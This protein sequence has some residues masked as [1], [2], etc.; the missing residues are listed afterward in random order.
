MR[1][2]S[3][4]ARMLAFG[5]LFMCYSA[6][7]VLTSGD[8]SNA[9]LDFDAN[10]EITEGAK[11][12]TVLPPLGDDA[13]GSPPPAFT[14]GSTTT[15]PA[16]DKPSPGPVDDNRP[17]TYRQKR[18]CTPPAIEQFPPTILPPWFR[19]RGGLIIH[20]LIA[21]FTFLGLAIVCDDYFVSS[22]DRICEELRLSPDVAGA[23]FMAAGMIDIC[24]PAGITVCVT[25]LICCVLCVRLGGLQAAPHRNWEPSSSACSSPRTISASAA[26]SDRPCSTSC[27]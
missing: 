6:F 23:T 9:P 24:K 5:I 26:S 21:M 7:N 20:I 8:T 4:R 3:K 22:L 13:S 12:S 14:D 27:L 25:L 2:R 18:N 11:L 1:Q 17:R 15:T 19:E 10:Q 16:S